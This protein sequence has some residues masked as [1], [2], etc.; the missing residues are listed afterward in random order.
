MQFVSD[1]EGAARPT[2]VQAESKTTRI[3]HETHQTH[4]KGMISPIIKKKR[5]RIF[6][7]R[8]FGVFRG[9]H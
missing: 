3:Y 9:G 5:R 2:V 7:L 8:V 1:A 4:E 6:F